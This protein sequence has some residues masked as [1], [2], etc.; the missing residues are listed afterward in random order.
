M[1]RSRL[2][3]HS[4]RALRR[5]NPKWDA[6]DLR[7]GSALARL[8]RRDEARKAYER[9]LARHPELTEARDSL[10]ALR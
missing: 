10:E 7:E 4:L 5:A 3:K 1:R 8:G 2:I 6:A 9:S